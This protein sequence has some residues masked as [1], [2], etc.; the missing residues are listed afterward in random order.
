ML[1]AKLGKDEVRQIYRKLVA[2]Y[3]VWGN[4]TESKARKLSLKLAESYDGDALLEVAVGKGLTLAE[5]LKLNPS[6]KNEGI[7]LTSIERVT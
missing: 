2:G 6:R 1:E 5:I 3:D 4:L 7:E